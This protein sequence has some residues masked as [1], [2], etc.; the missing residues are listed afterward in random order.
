MPLPPEN[1]SG[2]VPPA[3]PVGPSTPTLWL[4]LVAILIIIVAI[5]VGYG[6]F[7][8]MY[9]DLL[10]RTAFLQDAAN[11]GQSF[12]F[13]GA[14]FSGMAFAAV[15]AALRLQHTDVQAT[16]IELRASLESQRQLIV[17][18]QRELED[19]NLTLQANLF[20]TSEQ[21]FVSLERELHKT[22]NVFSMYGIDVDA[23]TSAGVELEEF[24]YLM[25]VFTGGGLHIRATDIRNRGTV[26]RSPFVAGSYFRRL[27]EF[28]KV[29][30]VW[31][32]LSKMLSDSAF[33]A[34]VIATLKEIRS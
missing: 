11:F 1:D 13:L 6:A 26:D 5:C 17:L 30:A 31:P 16:L 33:K 14:I 12:G 4:L 18:A 29:Q 34:K 15:V 3:D 20:A 28:P 10:H 27:L 22:P 7:L 19:N 2:I 25:A 23:V 21:V 8:L 32:E 9:P 24:S